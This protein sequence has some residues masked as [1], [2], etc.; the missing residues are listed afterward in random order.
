MAMGC[1]VSRDAELVK[2]VADFSRNDPLE[3]QPAEK[4]CLLLLRR[5]QKTRFR[6]RQLSEDFTDERVA[7]RVLEV[8]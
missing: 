7:R 3:F 6:G 1:A 5:G 8:L 2:E 4:I